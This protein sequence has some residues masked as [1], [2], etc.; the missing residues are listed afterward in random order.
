MSVYRCPEC[1]AQLWDAGEGL[2]CTEC[3]VEYPVADGVPLLSRNRDYYYGHEVPRDVMRSI[4]VRATEVG[5]KRA[6]TE[7]ADECGDMGFYGYSASEARAGFKFLLDHFQEGVVLDYGCGSG[8]NTL[9]LARNFSHVFA[10][11]LTP[12]RAQFTRLR[13]HQEN[14][15]NV[16]VFC[17]GDTKHIPLPDHFVDV[18][19]VDGVLEWVPES[20][21]GEPSRV[22]IDFLKELGRVL[23]P[24]GH[25]FI[26]IENR[27]G[28][29]YFAGVREEHTRMR[30]VSLLPRRLGD[31]YSQRVR[32]KPIRT[33]T[34]SRSGYRSLLQAAGVGVVD[35]WGLLPSYRLMEKALALDNQRMMDEALTEVTWRKRLRNFLVRPILPWMVGSF[36]ILAGRVPSTPYIEDLARHVAKTYSARDELKVLRYWQNSAGVVHVHASTPRERYMLELPL[37]PGAQRRLAAAVENIRQ[38]EGIEGVSLNKLRVPRPI[39]WECYRGQAFLLGP[40]PQGRGLNDQV[41]GAAL[42]ELLSRA[43]EYLVTL[44]KSTLRRAGPWSEILGQKIRDYGLPL[45][46]Q[47]R[48]RGLPGDIEKDILQIADSVTKAAS[49]SEGFLCSIHGDFRP[50]NLLVSGDRASEITAVLNWGFFEMQSLPFLDLFHFMAGQGGQSSWGGRVVKLLQALRSESEDTSVVRDYAKQVNVDKSMIP[51][52]LIV[53]WIRQCLLRL[54]ADVPQLAEV[55]QEGISKPLD[56]FR[57][58]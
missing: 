56:S 23:K 19:I 18:V 7:H 40:E 15:S 25:L 39:A 1:L 37:H 30:F 58:V 16:S 11:D 27:F 8:A 52:F 42:E 5:W 13:A 50:G 22:Q 12:E 33:Y 47:Y 34:Y 48:R 36:G 51:L 20:R 44:C 55:L 4:L 49:P 41:S 26:T 6:L 54:Q 24:N 38:L 32:G 43:G 28:A 45:A 3:S 57:A 31:L 17:C 2:R 14:L 21:P 10:T 9:S 29:G 46:K 53:Y 35:F